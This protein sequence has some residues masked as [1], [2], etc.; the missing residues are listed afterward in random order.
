MRVEFVRSGGFAGM[1]LAASFDTQSM[2][3]EDAAMLEKLLKDADFFNLSESDFAPPTGADRFQYQIKVSREEGE[4]T[5]VISESSLTER[6][7]LRALLDFLT[8]LARRGAS[9]A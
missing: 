5:L 8:A 9:R 7:A 3:N 4:H 1:R 6:G 2:S